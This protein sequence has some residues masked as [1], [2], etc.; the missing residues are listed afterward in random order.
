MLA[1]KHK[2]VTRESTAYQEASAQLLLLPG[3]TP[4]P[5]QLGPGHSRPQ[6][7]RSLKYS[8]FL[9]FLPIILS[10][11][12]S[13][14]NPFYSVPVFDFCIFLKYLSFFTR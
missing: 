14:F 6:L 12:F 4:A 3:E 1:D 5:G 9:A 13:F 8:A 7:Y 11:V 2:K 10:I